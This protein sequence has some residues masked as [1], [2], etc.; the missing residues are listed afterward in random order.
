MKVGNKIKG[1]A[2]TMALILSSASSIYAAP[3]FN[4]VT[5]THWAYTAISTVAE[6]GIIV[7]DGVNYN[8]TQVINK[9][10][11][12]KIL[13][14][15]AG[16]SIISDYTP[17]SSTTYVINQL[18]QQLPKTWGSFNKETEN[19]IAYLYENNVFTVDNLTK[20]ASKYSDGS[21][22]VN[23][24][25]KEEMA[26]F[27]VKALGLNE[28]AQTYKSNYSFSDDSSIS[29]NAKPYIYYLYSQKVISGDNENKFNPLNS[30]TRAEMATLLYKSLYD[31]TPLTKDKEE[32]TSEEKPVETMNVSSAEGKISRIYTSNIMTIELQDGNLKVCKIKEDVLVYINGE[33]SSVDKLKEGMQVF[34]VIVDNEVSEI[35]VTS[36][37]NEEDEKESEAK[38]NETKEDK[39]VEEVDISKLSGKSYTVEYIKNLNNENVIGVLVKTVTPS[40][41]IEAE[42]QNF[43]I[44]QNCIMKKSSD[45][46]KLSDIKA[47]D[48]VTLK[49]YNGKVYY[50]ELEEKNVI[51]KGATLTN[52]KLN[53]SDVPVITVKA[54]DGAEYELK[55]V[56]T[57]EII[58]KGEGEIKWR[59]LRIGDTLEIEKEY[60]TII[61]L[62][63]EGSYSEVSGWVEEIKISEEYP[64]I[65]IRD[66]YGINREYRV[67]RAKILYGIKLGSK[68][69]A[70]LSS[71]E[72]EAV[73]V[74]N[75][76]DDTVI[77]GTVDI[78]K[79]SYMYVDKS[80]T[81]SVRVDF[82]TN[83]KVYDAVSDKN[84]KISD[85]TNSMYV[86]VTFTNYSDNVAKKVTILSK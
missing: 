18:K 36:S 16:Y 51:L 65:V 7:G 28:E 55:I 9:F 5:D 75:E 66:S 76:E 24:L 53:A 15:V 71:Q 80:S 72:I 81:A 45:N 62:Y 56:S 43:T 26:V 37:V 6:K 22:I 39:T 47:E 4:D 21:E 27:L 23:N 46:I 40:G 41:D 31:D 29:E 83:T 38:D 3:K 82:D 11:T 73:T 84:V 32:Q 58:R 50:I 20:L 79:S 64:S 63:A 25:T 67:S 77:Y 13:A 35:R 30:I 57:S 10:D 33:V 74:I 69:T 19:S 8:P 34:V 54:K 86:M 44:A 49:V 70:V 61:S 2:V 1:V 68:I 17:K 78:A 12:A 60:N 48:V 85:L 59:E 42:I 14:R 52:K